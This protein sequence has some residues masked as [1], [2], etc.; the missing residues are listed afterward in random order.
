MRKSL[1]I[2]AISVLSIYGCNRSN[3]CSS[4]MC[5]ISGSKLTES[6]VR[7]NSSTFAYKRMLSRQKSN[8]PIQDENMKIITPT[9]IE[10]KSWQV[11]RTHNKW[12]LKSYLTRDLWQ[13]VECNLDGKN[14]N[15]YIEVGPSGP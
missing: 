12:L 3:S 8:A 5:S 11:T 10:P 15:Y 9:P 14:A 13:V 7:E 1:F 4:G 2:I 6:E